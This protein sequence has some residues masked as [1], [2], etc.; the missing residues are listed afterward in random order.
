VERADQ[1]GDQTLSKVD[2]QFPIVKKPTGELYAD[3]KNFVLLPLHRGRQ[4]K[5]HVF[6]VYQAECK[7]SGGENVL[8]YSKA[9]VGTVFTIGG[10]TL[11][12]VG[13][14]LGS[15]KAEVKEV[16]NEKVNH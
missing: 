14:F 4:G 6:G 1:L 11:D 16:T 12:W 15:K 3:A 7:K 9:L 8:A 2:E 10:E 13:T 5:E